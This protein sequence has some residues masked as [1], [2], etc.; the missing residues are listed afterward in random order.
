MLARVSSSLGEEAGG[1]ERPTRVQ[2]GVPVR[3]TVAVDEVHL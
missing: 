3:T 2:T 1:P